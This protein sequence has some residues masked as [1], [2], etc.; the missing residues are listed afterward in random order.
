MNIQG[1]PKKFPIIAL[2]GGRHPASDFQKG[3]PAC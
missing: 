2:F 1:Q 3:G